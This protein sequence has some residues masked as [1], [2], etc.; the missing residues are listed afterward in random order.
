MV[1]FTFKP[2][3]VPRIIEREKRQTI[4]HQRKRPTVAGDALQ[5]QTGD[6]FHPIRFGTAVCVSVQQ[7]RLD[8]QL[9]QV[10]LDDAV[11]ISRPAELDAF[12][13]RDGFNSPVVRQFGVSPWE[14]MARWWALTHPDHAV[15]L[16][17]LVDWSDTFEP[18]PAPPAPA[19]PDP[20]HFGQAGSIAPAWVTFAQVVEPNPTL[21]PEQTDETWAQVWAR[22]EPPE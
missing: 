17:V 7:V 13:T 3:F 1:G 12:A 22:T 20:A 18:A 5:L 15:F 19:S 6:R 10:L 8:F 2:S 9:G 14:V 16:G 4:R 21:A 11:M